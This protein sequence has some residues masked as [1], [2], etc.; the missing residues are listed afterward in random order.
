MCG[1]CL[2][3]LS[4]KQ[5]YVNLDRLFGGGGGRKRYYATPYKIIVGMAVPTPMKDNTNIAR[6]HTYI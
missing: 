1:S 3:T 5:V 4:D 6:Q 2:F